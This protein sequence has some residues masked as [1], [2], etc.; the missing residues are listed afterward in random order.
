MSE[1]QGLEIKTTDPI[2][3]KMEVS[4]EW[5]IEGRKMMATVR[6]ELGKPWEMEV[7]DPERFFIDTVAYPMVLFF[8]EIGGTNYLE[9][10]VETDELG[11]LVLSIQKK[12]GKTPHE[13]RKE[14]E[15]ERDKALAEVKRLNERL[16]KKGGTP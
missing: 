7:K 3:T 1:P 10:Q 15:A 11:P 6:Q 9:M 2:T 4:Q 12:W 13:L 14:A 8:K 16:K 5:E